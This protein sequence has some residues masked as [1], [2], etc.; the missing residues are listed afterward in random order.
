MP[1][2][3]RTTFLSQCSRHTLYTID[4]CAVCFD[5]RLLTKCT[6][7]CDSTFL[8]K[9]NTVEN[10]SWLSGYYITHEGITCISGSVCERLSSMVLWNVSKNKQTRSWQTGDRGI[11]F[12]GFFI[13]SLWGKTDGKIFG[14]RARQNVPVSQ[15]LLCSFDPQCILFFPKN[16]LPQKCRPHASC[17]HDCYPISRLENARYDGLGCR[18]LLHYSHTRDRTHSPPTNV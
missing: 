11:S 3:G 6:K 7:G 1:C 10:F 18:I 8:Q 2:K 12:P 14:T 4:C 16:V 5:I 17:L 15:A 9:R 13:F